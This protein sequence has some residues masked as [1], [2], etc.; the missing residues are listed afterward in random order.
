MGGWYKRWMMSTA[1][2]RCLSIHV[3]WFD[4]APVPSSRPAIVTAVVRWPCPI[5]GFS[6]GPEPRAAP[7]EA[8]MARTHNLTGLSTTPCFGQRGDNLVTFS[9]KGGAGCSGETLLIIAIGGEDQRSDMAGMAEDRDGAH[10]LGPYAGLGRR[11][12]MRPFAPPCVI[13]TGRLP[14]HKARRKQDHPTG[15]SVGV[16]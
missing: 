9:G 16:G 10:G 4:K 6:A 5:R 2:P 11:K 1:R 12:R 7:L 8:S 14:N 15:S 3:P 13:L